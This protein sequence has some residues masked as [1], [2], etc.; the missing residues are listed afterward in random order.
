MQPVEK[1]RRSH[2][3][4]LSR[5][6][7]MLR[8]RLGWLPGFP[9]EVRESC[10]AWKTFEPTSSDFLTETIVDGETLR[11]MEFALTK[12]RHQFPHAL[13]KLTPSV[14][15]W[16]ARMDY[17]L[18]ALKESVHRKHAID[19][20]L[21]SESQLIPMRWRLLIQ[22]IQTQH[23]ELKR[24]LNAVLFQQM[25][26]LNTPSFHVL[27]WIE[28]HQ[29]QFVQLTRTPLGSHSD[30]LVALQLLILR[31]RKETPEKLQDRL[32]DILGHEVT[33]Q[34]PS[35]DY[36]SHANWVAKKIHLRLKYP[37]AEVALP[38]RRTDD[39]VGELIKS[40][41]VT[42][43]GFEPAVR[44]RALKLWDCL[45]APDFAAQLQSQY[46]HV[47]SEESRLLDIWNQL[48]HQSRIP[49]EKR[50]HWKRQARV[51]A[52]IILP[53]KPLRYAIDSMNHCCQNRDLLKAWHEFFLS[54]GLENAT[55]R[56]VVFQHWMRAARQ[57]F[58]YGQERLVE[59]L[60]CFGRASRRYG[61]C[62]TLLN[63]WCQ[64]IQGE[65]ES[66]SCFVEDY[67]SR[68]A[69]WSHG[70]RLL[71]IVEQLVFVQKVEV[72]PKLLC[73][74]ATFLRYCP[75]DQKLLDVIQE[76][77]TER[78]SN[79][80]EGHIQIALLFGDD[81]SQVCSLLLSLSSNWLLERP[82]EHLTRSICD[83]ELR[84]L[85]RELVQNDDVAKLDEVSQA[86]LMLEAFGLK[87]PDWEFESA[88]TGWVTRYPVELRESLLKLCDVTLEAR[89]VAERVMS[90]D[91]PRREQVESELVA[92][93]AKLDRE[94]DELLR[95]H[96]R[97]RMNHLLHRLE[98]QDSIS[99]QRMGRLKRKLQHRALQLKVEHILA[100]CRSLVQ[101]H[102]QLRGLGAD[103]SCE[104]FRSP[105]REL[106]TGVANLRG[107]TKT[108]GLRLLLESTSER[109]WNYLPS[110]RNELFQSR[111][112][113]LGVDLEPWL[114]DRTH[115]AG[116]TSCGQ[117]YT[118]RW[119][120]QLIDY[121]LMGFHFQT[122]L[123]PDDC[124]FF[125]TISNAVDVNKQVLYGK[126]ESGRVVG[127]CLFALTTHGKILTFHRYAHNQDDGFD[128]LV[129][130]FAR[131]LADAMR[132]TLVSHGI[133]E[134]LGVDDW[135]NDGPVP[136]GGE[137]D[138]QSDDSLLLRILRDQD[139]TRIVDRLRQLVGYHVALESLLEKL[140]ELE[141]FQKRSDIL[142]AFA[143]RLD[144]SQPVEL[145][146]QLRLAALIYRSGHR[147]TALSILNRVKP[148]RLMAVLKQN[149]CRYC[150]GFHRIGDYDV[151]AGML[152]EFNPSFALRVLRQT[153]PA[154]VVEDI[155]EQHAKRRAALATVHSR[156][157]RDR[158][159]QKLL[160]K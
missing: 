149:E 142:L 34:L 6:R 82:I 158:L 135:Y 76:L 105:Y 38:E 14:D 101:Q 127:R 10:I 32:L 21:W 90:K 11:E 128:A 85:V 19:L 94:D 83:R 29:Q 130:R 5:A 145:R 16:L 47:A 122:C 79:Y 44:S 23:P 120:K 20:C 33:W 93:Q 129:D 61:A 99:E 109:P 70:R 144:T 125:S 2:R 74:V 43:V 25:T 139:S 63:Q 92:I 26:G 116:R 68:D 114:D 66:S 37:D 104:F 88:E 28:K 155:D 118:V 108:L 121:F 78:D 143:E 57:N 98:S 112:K 56:L 24:I 113:S 133:V 137:W 103:R 115:L 124:N 146:Y 52:T 119:T 51:T 36:Y 55:K 134:S 8:D 102:L 95:D 3:Q 59:F 97:R 159:V 84:G 107:R 160:Q 39:S 111:M 151:V 60:Q 62:V 45:I 80:K 67:L 40:L 77:A 126:T 53:I 86:T 75:H 7:M 35:Q 17:L 100:R 110:S 89:Q 65:S 49:R 58:K 123:A 81:A 148:N 64:Q 106:F 69:S 41:L 87:F 147:E 54:C 73:S 31:L 48:D 117:T 72:G 136:V 12:L 30:R 138:L 154:D 4:G 141:E 71:G 152:V 153:R 91:L 13:P 15:R 156:L 132:T 46:S 22:R 140:L 9:G 18:Q 131:A 150:D 27:T 50:K 1:N 96:L 157:G 42:L